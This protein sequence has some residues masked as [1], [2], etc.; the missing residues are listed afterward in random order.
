MPAKASDHFVKDEERAVFVREIA[1]LL[2][3]VVCR[4]VN[5]D[6]LENHRRDLPG[7]FCKKLF[8]TLNVVVMKCETLICDHVRYA[9][10]RGRRADEPIVKTEERVLATER[11]QL[12]TGVSARQTN[13]SRRH[14]RAILRKLHHLRRRDNL[15][16]QLREL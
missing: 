9:G 1:H 10:V 16:Q 3:E 11:D 2:Q 5:R 4:R 7:M 12:A 13:R 6:R 14:V 15:V 8:K